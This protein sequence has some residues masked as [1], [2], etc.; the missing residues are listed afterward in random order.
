MGLEYLRRH[1]GEVWQALVLMWLEDSRLALILIEDLGLQLAM[2]FKRS[3][4]LG[5]QVLSGFSR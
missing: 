4:A 1:A 5:E 3:V 2:P